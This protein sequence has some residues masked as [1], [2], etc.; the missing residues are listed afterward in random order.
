MAVEQVGLPG[1]LFFRDDDRLVLALVVKC[2]DRRT[3]GRADRA[4][5]D[6]SNW[7]SNDGADDG[8]SDCA[9][10]GAAGLF[11]T[12]GHPL[13]ECLSRARGRS[14]RRL[15]CDSSTLVG[16][17]RLLLWVARTAPQATMPNPI[18]TSA[19]RG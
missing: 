3:R 16:H 10:D 8:P 11:V 13:L 15:G 6:R 14:S 5:D 12:V 7:S 17:C 1:L 4:A 9:F 18:P 19:T 2:T